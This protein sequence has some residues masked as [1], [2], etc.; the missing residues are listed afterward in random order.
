[1][2]WV[3][4]IEHA[5]LAAELDR[6]EPRETAWIRSPLGWKPSVVQLAAGRQDQPASATPHTRGVS[7]RAGRG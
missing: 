6:A 1:M 5:G 7:L 3:G 2:D 4:A